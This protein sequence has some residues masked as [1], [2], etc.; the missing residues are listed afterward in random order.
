MKATLT[1]NLPED[2]TE[3]NWA[4]KAGDLACLLEEFDEELRKTLKYESNP[5]W[6]RE[7][8]EEIRS[9]LNEMIV[10]RDLGGIL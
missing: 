7:T 8:V 9:L 5:S 2:Q 3:F 1:F 10:D 4:N 6:N